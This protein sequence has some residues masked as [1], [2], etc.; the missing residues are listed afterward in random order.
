MLRLVTGLCSFRNR[1]R[2]FALSGVRLGHRLGHGGHQ[3]RSRRPVVRS[4]FR[5]ASLTATDFGSHWPRRP[6]RLARRSGAACLRLWTSTTSNTTRWAGQARK[7]RLPALCVPLRV[8]SACLRTRPIVLYAH[9]TQGAAI[10]L[11][12]TVAES[13]VRAAHRTVQ[14]NRLRFLKNTVQ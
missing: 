1:S 11:V 12:P 13:G 6:C 3:H 5:I 9:G 4:S 14:N 8:R 7:P 2:C 10:V